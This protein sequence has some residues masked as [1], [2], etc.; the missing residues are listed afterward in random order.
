MAFSGPYYDLHRLTTASTALSLLAG[1]TFWFI[2]GALEVYFVVMLAVCF[3]LNSFCYF[4]APLVGDPF[5]GGRAIYDEHKRESERIEERIAQ[6]KDSDLDIQLNSMKIDMSIVDMVRTQAE[7]NRSHVKALADFD[8]RLKEA[9]EGV[10]LED[11]S[12][13]E[14]A[15][16]SEKVVEINHG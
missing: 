11:A 10:V 16:E 9:S 5:A 7:L 1:A 14:Y 6:A 15:D 13:C 3:T 12:E 2:G 8:K 4:M